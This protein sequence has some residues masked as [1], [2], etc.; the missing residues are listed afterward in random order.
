[1]AKYFQTDTLTTKIRDTQELF[2]SMLNEVRSMHIFCN[3]QGTSE[4][5]MHANVI[6]KIINVK[7]SDDLN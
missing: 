1:M 7:V 3:P 6:N 4:F 5:S 2:S